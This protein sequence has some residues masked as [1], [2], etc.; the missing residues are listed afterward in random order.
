M[1][2]GV[3]FSVE[4][5]SVRTSFQIFRSPSHRRQMWPIRG[6]LDT[7]F[8]PTVGRFVQKLMLDA[9]LNS[10]LTVRGT[11]Q[12]GLGH[13][14]RTV[15]AGLMFSLTT[16][17]LIFDPTPQAYAGGW[18][19][20]HHYVHPTGKCGGAREVLASSYASG[21]RVAWR[22]A[23]FYANGNTA[24]SWD[25][26]LG[27]TITVQNPHN[28]RTLSILINDRGP[29]GIARRMGA[30]LDLVIGAA[31]RLGVSTSYVCVP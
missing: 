13:V 19:T 11:G 30:R 9:G 22:S 15:R 2:R 14:M 21:S 6:H 27:T 12:T 4:F 28:G 18:S 10:F 31:R 24:A 26:P 7:Q 23:K 29:N 17:A 16:L 8:D 25:Y 1:R 3:T 5:A 20:V